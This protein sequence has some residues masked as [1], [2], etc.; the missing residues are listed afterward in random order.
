[1]SDRPLLP[2]A[3]LLAAALGTAAALAAVGSELGVRGAL[4]L[5]DLAAGL[6]SACVHL[7]S[8]AP[9][10]P[11][12][13]LAFAALVAASAASGALAA[14][15]LV[16][17]QRRLRRLP[18]RR[19]DVAGA[20]VEVVPA[21]TPTAF[22]AGLLRPRVVVSSALVDGL[23]PDELR[24]AIA[25]E[26]EHARLR[27]PLLQAL[28][29][30][31]AR[32]LF[33]LPVLGDLFDRFLLLSELAADRAAAAETSPGALAGALLGVAAPTPAGAV[34]MA[35]F[36]DARIDRLAEPDAPLPPLV[37]RRSL[38][39]TAVAATALAL[40]AAFPPT[41]GAAESGR[42]GATAQN[43]LGDP[44]PRLTVLA[45]VAAA[46]LAWR[47]RR[48]RLALVALAAVAA[49]VLAP[50]VP[51]AGPHIGPEGVPVPAGA[52]LAPVRSPAPGSRVDGIACAPSEQLVYHIHAHLTIFVAGRARAIPY[53]IGIGAPRELSLTPL[54]PFVSGGS[55]FSWLHTHAADGIVHIESPTV[56]IYTLGDFFDVWGQALN[57]SQVGPARGRV[58]AF[59][60]GRRYP[61]SPRSIPLTPHAQIQLD[62][63]A[64]VV[65]PVRI[66][67]PNGL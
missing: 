27:V 3:A 25:H 21:A 6:A 1:M 16:R 43:L 5:V 15:R 24:A 47:L 32:T 29:A 37:R 54:G 60:D 10:L 22:C 17:E 61:G 39:A 28:A 18:T 58:T 26:L 4:A 36:A 45:A 33:W 12:S 52:P 20:A 8:L 14:A 7:A 67:F 65:A 31:A 63:G 62:V 19:R 59:Y 13:T 35:D 64:P 55:C 49:A 42:I 38:A 41:L 11:A 48:R 51:A 34:G 44:A 40:L 23:E 50:A 57:G 66:A 9:Q 30:V 53:G 2:L 46:A 56:R